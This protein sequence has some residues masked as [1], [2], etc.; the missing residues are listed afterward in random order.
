ML[1]AQPKLT[2][3]FSKVRM[4]GEWMEMDGSSKAELALAFLV[5]VLLEQHPSRG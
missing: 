3:G 1:V 5:E 2:S 4:G